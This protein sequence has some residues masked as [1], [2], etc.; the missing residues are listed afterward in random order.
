MTFSKISLHNIKYWLV[1]GL[2]LAALIT[3]EQIIRFSLFAE[4]LSTLIY[5]S[6]GA[7]VVL[8]TFFLLSR[9]PKP[10][11]KNSVKTATELSLREQEVLQLMGQGLSNRAIAERLFLSLATVKTHCSNIYQKLEVENRTQAVLKAQ[12]S[13]LLE[14]HPPV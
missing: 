14:A 9:E 5:W 3:L 7:L 2:A 4:G 10:A 13:G 12:Q 8:S 11:I 6:T 1:Y